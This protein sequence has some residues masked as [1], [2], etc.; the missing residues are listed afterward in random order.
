VKE[1]TTAAQANL[2]SVINTTTVEKIALGKSKQN[3]YKFKLKIKLSMT[4]TEIF[5]RW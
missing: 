1:E 2:V 5:Y 4:N 3:A